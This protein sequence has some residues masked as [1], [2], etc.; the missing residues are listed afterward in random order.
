MAVPI[1]PHQPFRPTIAFVVRRHGFLAGTDGEG[2]QVHRLA[3]LGAGQRQQRSLGARLLIEMVEDGVA[4]DQH[5]AIVQH[6]GGHS[7]Q[8]RVLADLQTIRQNAEGLVGERYI[9]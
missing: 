2:Q 3:A 9:Q 6:Q 4:V 7:T 8:R 1:V 5:P